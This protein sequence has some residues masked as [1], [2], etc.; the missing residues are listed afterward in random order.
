MI[1]PHVRTIALAGALA[2]ACVATGRAEAASRAASPSQTALQNAT[3]RGIYREPV[4]LGNGVYQGPPAAPGGSSRPRVELVPGGV[5]RGNL[6]GKASADAA[7]LLSESSGGSGS[8]IYLAVVTTQ[9]SRAVNVATTLVGDRVQVRSMRLDSTAIVL[10]L[11][12]HAAQDP[13]CCP[14][15]KV[16]RVWRCRND[17]LVVA[18]SRETGR[19]ST[20]DLEGPLWRLELLDR[21]QPAPRGVAI[22]ARF[23]DGKIEGSAGCNRYSG[24][25]EGAD[26]SERIGF[27]PIAVTRMACPDPVGSFEVRYLAALDGAQTFGF[28]VGKLSLG[29]RI[30]DRMGVMVFAPDSTGR[31]R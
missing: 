2:L 15:L 1:V 3:Y 30:G 27:G 26:A 24:A 11:I 18:S 31:T 25:V 13:M 8:R 5:A 10:D 22:T 21:S 28:L 20:R 14:T 7:V 19:V 23:A 16:T 9:G 4:T 29:Y 12:T 17:S 6:V